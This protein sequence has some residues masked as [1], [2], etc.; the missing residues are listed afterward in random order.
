[1]MLYHIG[2]PTNG[3]SDLLAFLASTMTGYKTLLYFLID[4]CSGFQ[5]TGHNNPFR[6]WFLWV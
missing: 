4:Y 5:A 3:A 1:M 6:F 2:L